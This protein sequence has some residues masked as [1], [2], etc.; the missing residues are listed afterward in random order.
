MKSPIIILAGL[1]AL[2]LGDL[3]WQGD[4]AGLETESLPMVELAQNIDEITGIWHGFPTGLLL[5]INEDGSAQFGQDRDGTPIGYRAELKFRNQ[6]LYVRF[7]D[8][9]ISEERCQATIGRYIVQI[10]E[11]GAI[12]FDPVQDDCHFRLQILKG[13]SNSG[14]LYHRIDRD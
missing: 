5:Q 2:I 3:D 1:L 11:S 13:P 9:S 12:H 7:I 6:Q 10:H 14:M 4:V 8:S